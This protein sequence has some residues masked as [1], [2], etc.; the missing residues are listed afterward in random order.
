M[1]TILW[2]WRRDQAVEQ[3]VNCGG[4]RLAFPGIAQGGQHRFLVGQPIQALPFAVE[5]D[6]LNGG[7]I[8]AFRLN[9]QDRHNRAADL[10]FMQAARRNQHAAT[11]PPNAAFALQNP[12]WLIN[13][14]AQRR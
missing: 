14:H 5:H 8:G 6:V 2:V 4:V 3:I 11:F 12:E 7:V 1:V 10:D 13:A 9:K